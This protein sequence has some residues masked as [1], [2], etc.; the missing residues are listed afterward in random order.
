MEIGKAPLI[1]IVGPTAVGKT[2]ISLKLAEKFNGEIISADSRLFYRGM[3]IG[4]AKPT[5]TERDRIPHHLIDVSNPDQEWSLARYLPQAIKIIL[6]VNR[7]DRLP[8]LVGGT[9]QYI[10]AIVEGWEI[11]AVQP[12]PRLRQVLNKWAA[13]VGVNGIRDRLEVVDPDA[14]QGIDGPNLRRMIRALEVI[15]T[16]GER[17][18]TQKSKSGSLFNTLQIG[19]IRPRDELYSRIDQRIDQ[20]MSSGLVNEVKT[21]LENGYSPN[22]SSMSAI[23]YKQI[24]SYLQDEITLEQ[25][26]RQIKSKTHKYVRQQANWFNE[27]APDIHWFSATTDPTD[28]IIQIIH[29][30]L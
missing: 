15:F 12:D 4:T 24:V 5:L 25:A 1:V 22:L 18:S 23:G 16:S 19:L 26:V 20:M 14:A 6:E 29:Q 7:Q 10:Q 9:G 17:F 3:D 13:E 30:F 27:N 28:Q 11:P 2:E 8:F 21:L